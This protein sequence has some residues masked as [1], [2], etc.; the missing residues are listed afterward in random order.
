MLSIK[1]F[2]CLLILSML[3]VEI[4][5]GGVFFRGARIKGGEGVKMT[6]KLNYPYNVVLGY[7]P[8]DDDK[9][10]ISCGGNLISLK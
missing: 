8:E 9:P 3:F 2:K 6:D 1:V 10:F 7:L 4:G 5:L